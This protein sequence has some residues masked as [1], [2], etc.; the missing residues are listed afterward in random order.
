MLSFSPSA[1]T[2]AWCSIS[3]LIT[4]IY[5]YST[6]SSWYTIGSPRIELLS[7]SFFLM[8]LIGFEIKFIGSNLLIPIVFYFVLNVLSTYLLLLNF[9]KSPN[10]WISIFLSGSSVLNWYLNISKVLVSMYFNSQLNVWLKNYKLVS[11]RLMN[12][13]S[14]FKA[15]D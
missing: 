10:V 13:L 2:S 14:G 15:S 9:T 5:S 3:P 7:N 1:M 6:I 11:V 12:S 8:F 4:F